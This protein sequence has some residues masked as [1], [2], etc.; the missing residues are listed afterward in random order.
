MEEKRRKEK[1]GGNDVTQRA[2]Q[3]RGKGKNV[4]MEKKERYMPRP[5][6]AERK[7]RVQ[8]SCSLSSSEKKEPCL[9][10]ETRRNRRKT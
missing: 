10:G 1:M 3:E 6:A 7:T 5:G 9:G 2:K 8:K 4:E